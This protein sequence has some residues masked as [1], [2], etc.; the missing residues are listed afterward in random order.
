MNKTET[1]R[2]SRSA[3]RA[4]RGGLV[5]LA[6]QENPMSTENE[7]LAQVNRELQAANV[8][9]IELKAKLVARGDEPV[10]LSEEMLERI[11]A[12]ALTR[13]SSLSSF[14]GVRA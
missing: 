4:R 11:E 5:R 3:I 9:W 12:A 7:R 6:N 14:N 1:A 13:P 2:R 8:K 10:V